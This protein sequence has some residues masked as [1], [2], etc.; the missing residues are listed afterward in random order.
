MF[1]VWSLRGDVWSLE[2]ESWCLELE[3]WCFVFA[4]APFCVSGD[5]CVREIFETGARERD[6]EIVRAS[7]REGKARREARPLSLPI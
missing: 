2:F 6:M 3:D 7:T 5:T 1:G 4:S